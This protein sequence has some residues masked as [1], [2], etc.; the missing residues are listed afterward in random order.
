MLLLSFD[1]MKTEYNG[2]EKHNA[3]YYI[4][5][6]YITQYISFHDGSPSSIP[7]PAF[8]PE[9]QYLPNNFPPSTF[10]LLRVSERERER[11]RTHV[12]KKTCWFLVYLPFILS[13]KEIYSNIVS[14]VVCL[15]GNGNGRHF[16]KEGRK[17]QGI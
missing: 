15:N 12:K 3:P 2:I 14:V 6:L 9:I 8:L 16:R 11:T 4:I 17:E 10:Y 7:T 5:L 1:G 13:G